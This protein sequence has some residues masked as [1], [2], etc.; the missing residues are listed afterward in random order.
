MVIQCPECS[1][2][3]KLA[4][5]KF[6]PGGMKV[7]CSRCKEV[8]PVLPPGQAPEPTPPQPQAEETPA[9]TGFG[10]RQEPAGQEQPEQGTESTPETTQ[11]ETDT[12]PSASAPSF[13]DEAVASS[14]MQQDNVQGAAAPEDQETDS[15]FGDD[16]DA[17]SFGDEE[18]SESSSA[19]DALDDLGFDEDEE[20]GMAAVADSSTDAEKETGDLPFDNEPSAAETTDE[21]ILFN[22]DSAA[23]AT[24]TEE[25]DNFDFGVETAE[26]TSVEESE[27]DFPFGETAAGE[28]D[29]LSFGDETAAAAA[30]EEPEDEFL[31]GE[32]ADAEEDDLSF[33]DETTA[34]AATEEP[35][36]DFLFEEEAAQGTSPI[37]EDD[38]S[39]GGETAAAAATEEPEDDFLFEEGAEQETAAAE[40]DDFSF[41]D[42][43]PAADA[44]GPEEDSL[45]GDAAP[46]EETDASASPD[47]F[48][49]EEASAEDFAF[50]EESPG[51]ELGF[52]DESPFET[53]ED[54]FELDT[55]SEPEA[56]ALNFGDSEATDD[57]GFQGMQFG[58]G[59]ES[60]SAQPAEPA[61]ERLAA[62]EAPAPPADESS[63]EMPGHEEYQAPAPE[64]APKRKSSLPLILLLLLALCGA[65]GYFVWQ[66]G[67]DNLMKVVDELMG[68][69]PVV[70]EKLQIRLPLP[71]SFFITN[72]EAGQLFVVQGEAVNAFDETRSAIAVKG[73]LHNSKGEILVQQ[74]VFAGNPIEQEVLKTLPFAKIEEK[75][76]NQFGEALSN[77][78]V[79]PGKS[80][81]YTI[82]FR[83]LPGDVTEF[84][85]EVAD[86]KPGGQQ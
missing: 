38:L 32:A 13:G 62:A 73:A 81:P 41:G 31:F 22:E 42:E 45:F 27:D 79:V 63:A 72:Q 6:K 21:E 25:E 48:A 44:D 2:R 16:E 82:V 35:E 49:F 3:F 1:T 80:I 29:D 43:I 37:E 24:T 58:E 46:A 70:S 39:F 74:T 84:T 54:S 28:E 50:E 4:D 64:A 78:N 66:T 8:F 14:A 36:D 52:E 23:Q 55:D 19:T 57:F 34:A 68:K 12:A 86:S 20:Q 18:P 51:D 67:T 47:E 40:E 17:I 11:A 59:S 30:T 7:R 83:G 26:E 77:L 71:H 76:N 75:M 53:A 15:A 5:E 61:A 65:A 9:E 85:I 60:G 56:A 69:K 10:P 33:G